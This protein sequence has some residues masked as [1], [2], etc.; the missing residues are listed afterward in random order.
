MSH[1]TLKFL[2]QHLLIIAI[3]QQKQILH[4]IEKLLG[5]K[6]KVIHIDSDP[7]LVKRRCSSIEKI[8]SQL[9]FEPEISVEEGTVKYIQY[10][11]EGKI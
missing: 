3:P 11:L 5:K 8:K 2:K 10:L 6:A 7:H 9:G 4:L 1:Q